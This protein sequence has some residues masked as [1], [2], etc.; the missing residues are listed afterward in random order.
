MLDIVWTNLL[1]SHKLKLC[2]YPDEALAL[3]HAIVRLRQ[4]EIS[5]NPK[6]SEKKPDD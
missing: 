1:I 2:L 3:G 5:L 6:W 4:C